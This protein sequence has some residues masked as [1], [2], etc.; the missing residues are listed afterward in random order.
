MF[1]IDGGHSG[2][3]VLEQMLSTDNAFERGGIGVRRELSQPKYQANSSFNSN[4]VDIG[5]L[6]PGLQGFFS[7]CRT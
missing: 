5:S 4:L 2:R 7:A 3:S 6:L 1:T